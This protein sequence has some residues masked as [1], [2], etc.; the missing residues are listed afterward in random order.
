MAGALEEEYVHK[1]KLFLRML[2]CAFQNTPRALA[3]QRGFSGFGS[4]TPNASNTYRT[5][6]LDLAPEL[7]QLRRLLDKKWRNQLSRADKNGLKVI[8]GNGPAEYRTF[9]GMYN[10]MRN[11]KVFDTTVDIEEFGRLQEALPEPH[12]MEVLI[13]EEGDRPVAGLVA[14]AMGDTAIYL[15]G[16]TS[17][18]GLNAKG[19]YLLQWTLIKRLKERGIR[20]YDLGGID[21]GHNPGVYHFKKGLSGADVVQLSPMV[22]CTNG[23]SRAVVKA[24]AAI[25]DAIRTCKPVIRSLRP[26]FRKDS[27]EA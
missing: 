10:Q 15:L 11:R 27:F 13:C 8:A 23:M 6:V 20:W 25:R 18:G 16:A 9:C 21:P 19:A 14:S 3:I 2:P 1:R 12:R 7:E 4:E 22:A 17:N 5:F 26:Q 24:G